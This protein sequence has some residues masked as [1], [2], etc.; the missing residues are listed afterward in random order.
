MIFKTISDKFGWM[1]P[2]FDFSDHPL[3][4][5]Q[6]SSLEGKISLAA[7]FLCLPY[8]YLHELSHAIAMK[9]LCDCNPEIHLYLNGGGVTRNKRDYSEI[10]KLLGKRC[11]QI[12]Y[13]SAGVVGTNV[14]FAIIDAA[15]GHFLGPT[16]T[17]MRMGFIA[18]DISYAFNALLGRKVTEH[19]AHNDFASL[20]K[21]GIHPLIPL[22]L[23]CALEIHTIASFLLAVNASK[24]D[25]SLTPVGH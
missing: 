11:S 22:S 1:V 25:E 14:S 5:N 6:R 19:R 7:S 15:L 21:R 20:N 4:K 24:N 3:M 23:L 10:G 16:F 12:I 18:G 9:I 8:I 13:A 2:D 17:A